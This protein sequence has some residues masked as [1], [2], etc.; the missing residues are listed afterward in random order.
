MFSTWLSSWYK[1][2]QFQEPFNDHYEVAEDDGDWIKVKTTQEEK[3]AVT[4]EPP[5]AI[6]QDSRVPIAEKKISRQ[7]RRAL[8][9]LETKE[10]KKLARH[11]P[12][13]CLLPSGPLSLDR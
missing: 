10:K 13:N 7:E 6:E 8:L 11:S 12:M 1:H 5:L 9:R 4:P 2:P 3:R